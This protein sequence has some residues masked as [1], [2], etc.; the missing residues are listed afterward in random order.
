VPDYLYFI[1]MNNQ[2]QA[3]GM[4]SEDLDNLIRVLSHQL[5]S[6]VNAIE[7]MLNVMLEGFTGDVD[8][9]TAHYLKKVA[10][11]AGEARQLIGDLLNYQQYA[12]NQELHLERL[13]FSSLLAA[14]LGHY[15][16]VAADKNISLNIEIRPQES[17][18]VNGSRTAL[19]TSLRNILENAIKY[20]AENGTI[21]VALELRESQKVC[22]LK[23][24]DSGCGIGQEDLSRLFTPFF[25][26]SSSKAS[27]AGTGLGLAIVKR[28]VERHQGSIDITSEEKK[29]TLVTITLPYCGLEPKKETTLPRKRVVIVGGVT[30]G[31][32]AAA[33]LRRLDEDADITI[34]EKSA[35]LSYAGCGI[36]S[37]V[38]GTV[39]SPKALMSTADNTLRDVHFFEAIKNIRVMNKT[40]A[41]S[42]DRGKRELL[43]RDLSSDRQR[44]LPYDILVLAT[45]AISIVP[46][47]PGIDSPGIYSLYNIE[48]AEA[49]KRRFAEKPAS[50]VCILGGGLVGVEIAE[51][52]LMAGGRIT[53]LEKD[54]HILKLFDQDIAARIQHA[55][56][57]KGIKVVTGVMVSEIRFSSG[58]H[59]IYT[60]AGTFSSD[61]II[62]SAGVKPNA[63]LA[64][65]A[66]LAIGQSGGIIVNEF[67]TTSDPSI[68]AIGDCAESK[69]LVTGLA[70]YLPLGSIST[71][72]GRIAADNIC[73]RSSRFLGSVGTTIFKIFDLQVART[74]L[75][76]VQAAQA[77]FSVA[78]VVVSGLDKSHYEAGAQYVFIKVLADSKTQRLLGAQGFGR[79]DVA[80]RIA[81]LASAISRGLSLEEVFELDLGY[82][83]AFNNPIDLGQT[84]CLV[85]KNK[86]EGLC[87]TMDSDEFERE[88]DSLQIVDVS[89]HQDYAFEAVPGSINVPLENLRQEGIPFEKS[90]R[91]VL[92]SK[93]SSRAYEAYRFL[94]A[95][96]YG[97]IAFL[98]GGYLFWKNKGI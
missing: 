24:R 17:L 75:Q 8:S 29:G 72:M 15:T 87:Q 91:V 89:P 95:C 59:T 96:G 18:F 45:G 38:R 56:S 36:P 7:S 84:A 63:S 90:A 43:V 35:L 74:G 21:S 20:T 3:P 62:L 12:T 71:K 25:R 46:P 81:V 30:A 64:G 68:Y 28:V 4:G 5:K 88:K 61:L 70:S 93:T 80:S 23:I 67:L 26:A 10:A 27:V 65:S 41:L 32:K 49:I 85:L 77:G 37:Y 42:I 52:L 39:K 22:V 73:G 1:T 19:E 60:S 31:P 6:P 47:I 57:L 66:G 51:S 82:Y 78:S 48:D 16:A 11:K 54:S 34:V 40:Q 69:H 97:N 44:S 58:Q 53:I 79:G 92:Y 14:L 2:K 98:E 9:K 76:A 86:I 50:D 55:L 94:R 33:R 83:P 13:D